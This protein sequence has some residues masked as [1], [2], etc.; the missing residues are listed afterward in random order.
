M[1]VDIYS[2]EANRFVTANE[3][4]GKKG[5]DSTMEK[6][7]GMR[8]HGERIRGRQAQRNPSRCVSYVIA[9]P[10]AE[11][12][13]NREAY[14]SMEVHKS[15]RSNRKPGCAIES[16]NIVQLGCSRPSR[17]EATTSGVLGMM[18]GFGQS[19]PV[20]YWAN[21]KTELNEQ[22]QIGLHIVDRLTSFHSVY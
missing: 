2:K 5:L 11:T 17:S 4:S 13:I 3:F 1:R 7:K 22:G 15:S 21:S 9:H 6:P 16:D 18:C 20:A 14:R 19:G 8:K 12:R 10:Q